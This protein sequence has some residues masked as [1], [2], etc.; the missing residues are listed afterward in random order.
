MSNIPLS[1]ALISFICDVIST[2]HIKRVILLEMKLRQASTDDVIL[3][4][5][6]LKML[7]SCLCLPRKTLVIL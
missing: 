3:E 6:K 7:Y 4:E 5:K 2:F 1:E